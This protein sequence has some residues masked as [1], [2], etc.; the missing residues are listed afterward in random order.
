MRGLVY[1]GDVGLGVPFNIASYAFL[2]H[3]LAVHCGLEA[4][5]FVHFLGNYHIYDDHISP[6]K[7]QISRERYGE[8]QRATASERIHRSF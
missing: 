4:S 7:E 8:R 2:T 5:S 1:I 6:L 3:L